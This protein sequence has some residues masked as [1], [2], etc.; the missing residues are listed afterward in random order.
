MILIGIGHRKP[1]ASWI[2]S[3][4]AEIDCLEITAEHFFDTDK[5]SINRLGQSYPT[6]VHGLG[7]SLGTPGPLEPHVLANFARVV[8]S[9]APMWISE[10]IAFT[11][12]AEVDLGHLNPIPM[13]FEM[14]DVVGQHAMELSQ[15][16]QKPIILENIMSQQRIG[17]DFEETEFINE[18]CSRYKCGLL[19]DVTNLLINSRNHLFDPVQWLSSIDPNHITQLHVVGYSIRDGRYHDSHSEAIQ[20]DLM[21]LLREV[22]NYGEVKAI[23]LERDD[24]KPA[25]DQ[26][27][28]EL[29]RIRSCVEQCKSLIQ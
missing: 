6:F 25:H 9:L 18:L 20:D 2:D 16:C 29:H 19:L 5:R 15:H 13:T 17:G 14:L 12:T 11:R 1:F 28:N 21:A 7:L 27:V 24:H 10:H 8:D 4:P 3:Q 26:I 23:I 22:V